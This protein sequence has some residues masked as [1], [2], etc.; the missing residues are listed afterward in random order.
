MKAGA[1]DYLDS[2][3]AFEALLEAVASALAEVREA[4]EADRSLDFARARISGMS[5]REH[6]VLE[7]LVAG[8]T[9]KLI[10]RRLGI[11]PRT[12]EVHRAHLMERLDVRSLP[13]LVLLAAAAARR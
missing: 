12:V 10:G 4:M 9:N 6:E 2:P 8:E 3:V 11:S 7:G 1:V 5:M 13:E